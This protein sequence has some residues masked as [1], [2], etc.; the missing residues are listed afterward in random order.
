MDN[1]IIKGIQKFVGRR[2]SDLEFEEQAAVRL[3]CRRGI[4][5]IDPVTRQVQTPKK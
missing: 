5:I 1:N 4:V 3:G 2:F